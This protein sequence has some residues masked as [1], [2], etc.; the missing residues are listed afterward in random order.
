MATVQD[1]TN[2]V[3]FF[4]VTLGGKMASPVLLL[5][6]MQASFC[7]L[8][9]PRNGHFHTICGVPNPV[10]DVRL[11]ICAVLRAFFS[12]NILCPMSFAVSL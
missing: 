1:P 5:V 11:A 7:A 8:A 6:L 4:D 10:A 2:P 12:A 3:V 9:V